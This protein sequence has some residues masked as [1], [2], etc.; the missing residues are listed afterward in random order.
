MKKYIC[1]AA[2]RKKIIKAKDILDA[3]FNKPFSLN[4]L[5]R[6]TGMNPTKLCELFKETQL[7]TPYEFLIELRA[8]E[9]IELLLK[10]KLRIYEIARKCGYA[11]TEPFSKMYKRHTG[12]APSKWRKL[13]LSAPKG[14]YPL[15]M[16]PLLPARYR[17]I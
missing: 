2:D 14:T 4:R 17:N 12:M 11:T 5:A 6:K 7:F 10:T 13:Q 9:A 8:E 16:K 15:I 1:T 3:E